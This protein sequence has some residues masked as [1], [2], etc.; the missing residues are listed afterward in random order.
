MDEL[1]YIT[2]ATSK[3]I[4]PRHGFLHYLT[5]I[6]ALDEG[7]VCP[8]GRSLALPSQR[9]FWR[10]PL[11]AE[12]SSTHFRRFWSMQPHYNC[13]SS[14]CGH[15]SP[16]ITV[17]LSFDNKHLAAR[18]E[19]GTLVISSTSPQFDLDCLALTRGKDHRIS[20]MSLSVTR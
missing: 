5:I 6:C 15:S 7:K 9:P 16:I 10:V 1:K 17:F 14:L 12:T 8:V 2:V 13:G 11:H 19:N 18:S 4:N 3:S 20:S